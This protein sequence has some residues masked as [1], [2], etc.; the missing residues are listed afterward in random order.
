MQQV[1]TRGGVFSPDGYG[2]GV[3]NQNVAFGAIEST[4]MDQLGPARLAHPLSGGQ[5]GAIPWVCWGGA[6]GLPENTA[7]KA[8]I[9]GIQRQM[10][11]VGLSDPALLAAA[12]SQC[13]SLCNQLEAEKQVY[14]GTYSADTAN[15]QSRINAFIHASRAQ[16]PTFPYCPVDVDGKLGPQTCTASK[17]LFGQWPDLCDGIGFNS[18]WA[19]EDCSG[20]HDVPPDSPPPGPPPAPPAPPATPPKKA[21]GLRL[22]SSTMIIGGIAALAA[23]GGIAWYGTE[24]GWFS[25]EGGGGSF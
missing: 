15:M 16:D 4:P 19:N 3:F 13:S 5:W 8:C 17:T 25:Q 21:G 9:A 6:S 23:I 12:Q 14:A 7:F 10:P 20:G 18:S 22:G 2:G 24:Q 11:G 1:N